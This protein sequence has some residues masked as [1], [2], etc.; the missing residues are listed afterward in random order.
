MFSPKSLL[1][2][3]RDIAYGVLLAVVAPI[4]RAISNLSNESED[5]W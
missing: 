4:D 2:A 1:H 3:L 5:Q